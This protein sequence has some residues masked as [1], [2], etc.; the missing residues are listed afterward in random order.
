MPPQPA[1]DPDLLSDDPFDE[2]EENEDE[3]EDTIEVEVDVED[4][5]DSREWQRRRLKDQARQASSAARALEK[6]T[7]TLETLN[8]TPPS[9]TF[10]F[11]KRT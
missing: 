6:R 2:E 10:R 3:D 1:R 7:K 11:K 8:N 5:E 9:R 4:L